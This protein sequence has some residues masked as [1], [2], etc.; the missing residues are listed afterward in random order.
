MLTALRGLITFFEQP[1]PRRILLAVMLLSV[2]YACY[3][4][5][6]TPAPRSVQYYQ[7][8]WIDGFYRR[9]LL[10]TL[11]YPLGCKRF[12]PQLIH[13]LQYVVFSG[14]L[15]QIC[16]A[17]IRLRICI[18]SAIYFFSPAGGFL[19]HT[20][21]YVEQLLLL[22]TGLS[23]YALHKNKPVLVSIVL[24]ACILI[25][26][27][28]LFVSVPLVFAYLLISGLVHPKLMLQIFALLALT[29]A[30]LYLGFQETPR[31]L[32]NAYVQ[33]SSSCKFF[34]R[35]KIYLNIFSHGFWDRFK[36]H[37]RFDRF[38][39]PIGLLFALACIL[40][41]IVMRHKHLLQK[42][43]LAACCLSPL[44]IGFFAWDL[45]R[46]VLLT[47]MQIFFVFMMALWAQASDPQRTSSM[48]ALFLIPFLLVSM[49]I[50]FR[51][52]TGHAPRTVTLENIVKFG[53]LR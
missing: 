46:W 45:H 19:F 7:F 44:L 29:F 51:Y 50:H 10:G 16:Y 25:H 30:T 15:A 35:D 27:M 43:L 32:I 13:A 31:T 49:T 12:D 33:E 3:V 11:L 8:S 22:L 42:S 6:R 52:F 18:F 14:L 2:A 41:A 5:L 37:Y 26:E 47:V 23:I 28:A 36:N 39:V 9:G 40:V 48:K 21:G 17:G 38:A 34:M 20:I 53:G 1:L 4:G 24:A